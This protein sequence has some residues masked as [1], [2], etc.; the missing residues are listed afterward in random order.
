LNNN[1]RSSKVIRYL[2]L[3][4]QVGG[5]AALVLGVHTMMSVFSGSMPEN[6]DVEIIFEDPVRIPY[7]LK[8]RND[9]YLEADFSMSIS[10]L[11]MD[12][13][14]LASDSEQVSIQPHTQETLELELTMPLAEAHQYL[15][16]GANI[17]WVISV[18]VTTLYGLISFSDTIT[19]SGGLQ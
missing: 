9:G 16:S 5:L 13:M 1:L 10:V 11:T 15:Q 3:V 19:T 4:V 7:G 18:K 14:E 2:I 8:P 12:G 6:K 17:S